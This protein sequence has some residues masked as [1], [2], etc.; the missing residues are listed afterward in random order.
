MNFG[1]YIY[2]SVIPSAY[3]VCISIFYFFPWNSWWQRLFFTFIAVFLEHFILSVPVFIMTVFQKVFFTGSER[4]GKT[5]NNNE[6]G[7]CHN[8]PPLWQIISQ[9]RCMPLRSR[10]C[11]RIRL[12]K[13]TVTLCKESCCRSG[14]RTPNDTPPPKKIKYWNVNKI[15]IKNINKKRRIRSDIL[16]ADLYQLWSWSSKYLKI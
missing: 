13:M 12:G 16:I 11:L 15:L 3:T 2:I 6:N 10:S 7:K 14:F 1:L 9:F 8:P 4:S 5:W